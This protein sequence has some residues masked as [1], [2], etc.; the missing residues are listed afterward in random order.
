MI[1][2]SEICKGKADDHKIVFIRSWNEWAEGNHIEP[3]L[4]YGRGYL[5]AI[6][7]VLDK[8]E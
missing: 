5:E 6:K 8:E 7:E 1:K 4:K 2:V 3:D